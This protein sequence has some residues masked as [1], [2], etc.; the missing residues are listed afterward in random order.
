MLQKRTGNLF[1][2]ED[3]NC[4]RERLLFNIMSTSIVCG[5]H[6]VVKIQN[7][8]GIDPSCSNKTISMLNVLQAYNTHM[9]LEF[10]IHVFAVHE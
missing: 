8:K 1:S 5:N 6:S 3:D 7:R 10:G 2:F 9:Y 4:L